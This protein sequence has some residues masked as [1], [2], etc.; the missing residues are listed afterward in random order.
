MPI[1]VFI[2]TEF[3]DFDHRELISIGAVAE[4]G[5]EFYAELTDFD[6]AKCSDFVHSIV[7]PKLG[8]VPAIIGSKMEV[9][10][11]LKSWLDELG[12]A[13]EICVDYSGDWE[14]FYALVEDLKTRA[15]PKQIICRDIWSKI[16]DFDKERYWRDYGRNDHHA[17]SDARAN[18]YAFEQSLHKE[19]TA[20]ND[21]IS[22][23]ST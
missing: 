8:N 7:L 9:G 20:L 12:G 1:R 18:K 23:K 21:A 5:R 15:V 6:H 11:A 13:I 10:A 3:T 4:D 2:D 14:L 22:E 16:S 19:H 17:L